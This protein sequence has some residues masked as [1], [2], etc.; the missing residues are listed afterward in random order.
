[1]GALSGQ[2]FEIVSRIAKALESIAKNMD[3]VANPLV[4]IRQEDAG[5]LKKEVLGEGEWPTRK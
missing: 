3:K 5:K 4:V 2:E 1:M